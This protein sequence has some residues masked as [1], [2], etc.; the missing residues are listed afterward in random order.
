MTMMEE[1]VQTAIRLPAE[2]TEQ[3]RRS[4]EGTVEEVFGK[5][6]TT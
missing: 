5:S 6:S 3:L 1:R 4:A 2:L